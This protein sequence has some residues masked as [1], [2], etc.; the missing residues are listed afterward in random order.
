MTSTTAPADRSADAPGTDDTAIGAS[1][2]AGAG[3]VAVL[4]EDV[5][6]T[7]G[8]RQV[9][10]HVGFEVRFGAVLGLLGHNGAGKSTLVKILTTL[11]RADSGRA[12]ICGLD[13]RRRAHDVRRSIAVATQQCA[14][15]DSLTGRQ[16]LELV[17][18]LRQVGSRA[19]VR[20][21]AQE[22]LE[23]FELVPSADRRAGTYSGG[24][25]RRLDLAA[26]LVSS[27]PVLFLDEP[28]TGVD[29]A[30]RTA[31]WTTVRALAHAGTAVVL[32]TQYLEEADALA[33][34]VTLLNA[35]RVV[36]T[37]TPAELKSR[38][39]SDVLVV[40]V[41]DRRSLDQAVAVA[42][43]LLDGSIRADPD[44]LTL[45]V[46]SD[47]ALTDLRRLADGLADEQVVVRRLGSQQP[48]LD[49]V[50]LHFTA[51]RSAA[52]P[53]RHATTS[54]GPHDV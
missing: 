49:D 31:L 28:T 17:G 41:A 32:T 52:D 37:G 22:L 30:T 4:A 29:P 51:P 10:D 48:S 53:H 5:C 11:L 3:D 1:V 14:V 39:G 8:S 7:Y 36:A 2:T 42:R 23:H 26:C 25:R 20:D 47:A 12:E 33:D 6:K 34:E 43:S 15:D 18:R 19:Q 38:V 46:E 24:M 21:R 13:V 44:R 50:F 16:N 54:E 35:G 40:E 27:P 45:A 9:L